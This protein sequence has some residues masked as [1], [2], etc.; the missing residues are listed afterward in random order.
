MGDNNRFRLALAA[1]DNR[2]YTIDTIFPRHF[3]QTAL[4]AGMPAGTVRE[5]CDELLDRTEPAIQAVLDSLPPRFP[6]EL[7]DSVV[8]GMTSRLRRLGHAIG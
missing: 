5:I 7:A 4:K 2:H 1:G 3:T 6:S 8:G